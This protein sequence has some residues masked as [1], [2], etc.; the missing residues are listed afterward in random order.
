MP[1]YEQ[2]KSEIRDLVN[3]VRCK[4]YNDLVEAE[5]TIGV[6]MA[7]PTTNDAG[8]PTG[9]A[10]RHN[11]YPAQAL[12]KHTN[13]KDRVAGLP[14]AILTIDAD[15]W[16]DLNDEEREALIDHE[17]YRL[18]VRRDDDSQIISD[19]H[20]RP[21]LKCRL[22]DWQLGGFTVIAKRH[23]EASA[24]RRQVKALVDEFGQIL[25]DWMAGSVGSRPEPPD[26]DEKPKR[27]RKAS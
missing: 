10:I 2:A 13:L 18:E 25:F 23:G 20:G 3:Q 19:D 17:L 6:L 26:G 16:E 8:E 1:T 14:D 12:I 22:H 5:V 24:E 11:G 27:G 15:N 9:P 7:R 21:K 4:H